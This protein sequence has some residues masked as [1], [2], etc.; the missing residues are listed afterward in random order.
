MQEDVDEGLD[1]GGDVGEGVVERRV[2]RARLDWGCRVDV[3][4]MDRLVHEPCMGWDVFGKVAMHGDML[5]RCCA[6]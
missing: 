3:A 2:R 6:E 5:H 1:V 4:H